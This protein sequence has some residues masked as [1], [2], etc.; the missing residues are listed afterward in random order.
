MFTTALHW[1]LSCT[2]SIQSIPPTY[3]S[4]ILVVSFL[5]AFSPI[6]YKHSSSPP[7]VLHALPLLDFV[8]LIVLGEEYKA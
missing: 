5:L 8:I 3:V 1:F 6:S 2:R 4:A 7:F